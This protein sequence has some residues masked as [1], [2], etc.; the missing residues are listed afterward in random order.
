MVTSAPESLEVDLDSCGDIS[1]AIVFAIL[2]LAYVCP[3][4]EDVALGLCRGGLLSILLVT[5]AL[6]AVVGGWV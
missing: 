2:I 1:S 5:V 6:L 3:A 4:P